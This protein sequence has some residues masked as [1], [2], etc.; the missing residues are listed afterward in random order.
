MHAYNSYVSNSE[1]SRF[2]VISALLYSD[3]KPLW[4]C[5]QEDELHDNSATWLP[6]N[7]SELL[8]SVFQAKEG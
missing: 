7:G 3:F 2:K 6:Y 4:V 5:Q 8:S 1:S